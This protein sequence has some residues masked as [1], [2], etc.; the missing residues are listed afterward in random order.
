MKHKKD[1]DKELD[2]TL[3]SILS[4]VRG[5]EKEANMRFD[6]IDQNMNNDTKQI[7]DLELRTGNEIDGMKQHSGE[8]RYQTR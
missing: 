8:H 2:A 6:S 7:K 1:K 5:N 4:A 3:N